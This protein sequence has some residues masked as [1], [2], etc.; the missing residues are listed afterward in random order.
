M[1][2]FLKMYYRIHSAGA[3]AGLPLNSVWGKYQGRKCM[4][5][6][7]MKR[8]SVHFN[9]HVQNFDNPVNAFAGAHMKGD[10]NKWQT[11][12]GFSLL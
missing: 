12:V 5:V 3:Y 7:R 6:K 10:R 2:N 1:D 4:E 8:F 11:I 9:C